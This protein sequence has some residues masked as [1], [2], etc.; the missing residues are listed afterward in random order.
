MQVLYIESLKRDLE[1][2][3]II[4]RAPVIFGIA[5]PLNTHLNP[6]GPLEVD[7]STYSLQTSL[8]TAL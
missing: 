7:S 5:V 6:V 4:I 3:I 1:T 2:T 8:F